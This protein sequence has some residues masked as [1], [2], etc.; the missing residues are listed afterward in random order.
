MRKVIVSEVRQ[1]PPNTGKWKLLEKGEA[2]FHSF[3]VDY[4]EFD[5]GAGNYS[6]AIV[7]WPNG[8]VEMARADRV[9]FTQPENMEVPEPTAPLVDE[10]RL[11]EL[12]KCEHRLNAIRE[13]CGYVENGSDAVVRIFQDDATKDW[14]A[15]NANGA[16]DYVYGASFGEMLDSLV[17][18]NSNHSN[19]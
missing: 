11:Q 18:Y 15:K 2:L 7:E 6:V 5:S 8:Q 14:F 17:A 9:R 10:K 4:E 19:K 12:L 3:G 16:D 1:D 13:F